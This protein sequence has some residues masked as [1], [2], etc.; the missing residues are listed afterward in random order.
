MHKG[1][2]RSRAHTGAHNTAVRMM[3]PVDRALL[4]P[5]PGILRRHAK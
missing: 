1:G 4:P 3:F 2:V 5:L